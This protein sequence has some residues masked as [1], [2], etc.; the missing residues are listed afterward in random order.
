MRQQRKA[1]FLCS[2]DAIQCYDRIVHSV[3]M[4]SMTRLGANRQ[5]MN[6]LFQQLQQANHHIVTAH[7]ISESPYGG[8]KRTQAG[9]L[10]FQGVP[11]RNG[12]GPI[13]WLAMSML[14]IGIMHQIG[15][16]ATFTS[17]MSSSK[18]KFCGFLIVDNADLL[19]NAPDNDMEAVTILQQFQ[20]MVD[21][22]EENL[23]VTGGGIHP[24]KSFWHLLDCKWDK[25][26]HKWR[27]KTFDDAPGKITI[28][29]P[30]AET[31]VEHLEPHTARV[32]LGVDCAPNGNQAPE[33]EHLRKKA[34][35]FADNCRTAKGLDKNEA[36]EGILTTVMATMKHPTAATKLTEADW[37]CVLTPIFAARLPKNCPSPNIGTS[38]GEHTHTIPTTTHTNQSILPC[39]TKIK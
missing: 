4:L 29:E 8:Q 15:F 14:L 19:R 30:N 31:R 5:A 21:C 37:D 12:M 16:V 3:A 24:E 26:A 34:E 9:L 28:K 33:R 1:G 7:G 18:V 10:P 2:N 22:W 20:A 39:T 27:H 38:T 36:R 23:R 11:Q 25:K 17:A 6:S 32:T 35:I 13:T